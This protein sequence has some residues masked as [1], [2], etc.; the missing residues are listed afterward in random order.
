MCVILVYFFGHA[1]GF[2]DG[3]WALLKDRYTY[4][5]V[6]VVERHDAQ[7]FTLQPARMVAW[8]AH[9][10]EPVDWMPGEKMRVLTYQQKKGCKDVSLR[11]AF[12]FYTSHG[13]RVNY[14]KENA[15]AGY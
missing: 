3:Q 5:D 8:Q 9:T 2:T 1:V 13:E 14:F 6:L 11:G 10:C 12:E 4:T 7:D 15:N